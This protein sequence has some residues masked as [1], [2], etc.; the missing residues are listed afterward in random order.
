MFLFILIMAVVN[1]GLGFALAVYLRAS[2]E[3]PLG[4]WSRRQ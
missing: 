3:R 1:T 4:D 2:P